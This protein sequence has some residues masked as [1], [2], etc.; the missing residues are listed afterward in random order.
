[1][2]KYILSAAVIA[3]V[4]LTAC[5]QQQNV[6]KEVT[7][8]LDTNITKVE[9]KMTQPKVKKFKVG[10]VVES[11]VVS[12]SA[13]SV[14]TDQVTTYTDEAVS[15]VNETVTGVIENADEQTNGIASQVI[16]VVQ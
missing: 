11:T 4:T 16:E 5:T 9:S 3:A 14:V 15:T 7:K 8:A 6:K 1:M 13:T 2:T 10:D 12:E